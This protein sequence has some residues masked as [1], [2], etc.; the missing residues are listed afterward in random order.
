MK[1]FLPAAAWLLIITYLSVTPGLQL[2]RVEIISADKI[3]HAAAYALLAGCFMWGA[4]MRKKAS[5]DRREL[6]IV[7]IA[8][9]GYGAFM[10]WIQG[11]FFPYRSF[12]YDDMI[13]NAAGA[14]LAIMA[15]R[16]FKKKPTQ[17]PR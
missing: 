5:L 8:A 1:S 9:A 11:T 16:L 13:A 10:E 17:A 7:F 2:P 15:Y 12:E 4:V 6:W 14:F 3:A